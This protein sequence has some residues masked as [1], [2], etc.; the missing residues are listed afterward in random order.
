VIDVAFTPRELRDARVAVV[1]DVLRASTTITQALAVGYRRV[2]C[3]RGLTEARA[4]RKPGRVLAGE[5]DCLRPPG[6]D[7]GNSPADFRLR[8]GDEVVLTTTNGC[9]ALLAAAETAGEVLVGCLLN[10]AALR[11]RLEH[12][13][14][15]VL[16][17]AGTD[18]EPAVEDA[19]VAGLIAA[20]LPGDRTDA[21]R[22][23]QAMARQFHDHGAALHAGRGGAALRRVGLGNDLA[24]CAQESAVETVGRLAAVVGGVA[25]VEPGIDETLLKPQNIVLATFELGA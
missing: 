16:V 9:P 19:Y 5:R 18:S 12:E 23:A 20:T 25:A 1:I 4:L 6:F 2:L 10:L 24:W 21:A 15:V 13:D 8:R 11:A 14:D 3:C 22:I 7:L 17:C